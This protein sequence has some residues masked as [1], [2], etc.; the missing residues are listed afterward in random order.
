M[1]IRVA[2]F[3]LVLCATSS[4]QVLQTSKPEIQPATDVL[5]SLDNGTASNAVGGSGQPG[6]GWFNLLKPDTYPATLKEVHIA[7]N[8]DSR[9]LASG[10]PIRIL[11]FVDPEGDGLSPR[12]Q[13]AQILQVT[14]N[15]PGS[16][17]RFEV[18]KP[19]SIETGAF[20][21]GPLD[22]ILVAQLPALINTPGT[23]LPAG[24]RSYYT[25]DNGQT[26]LNVAASFPGFGL[27]PG[28]WLIRAVVEVA[29]PQPI[30]TR[31]FYRKNKLRIVGR[32]F[33]SNVVVRINGERIRK[34]VNF[35]SASGKYIIRGT[36]E[37]LNLNAAGQANTLVVIVDDVA[38][39]VFHFTT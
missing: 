20:I 1:M 3:V 24:A 30:I 34:S 27:V 12:Q 29:T 33:S 23:F 16:F 36:P 39:E 25:L 37:E 19:L 5:L 10:A 11:I 2:L 15:R 13:P 35:D 9:G 17:E 32:N 18:P 21:I 28:S 22:S 26:F 6:F 14:S 8:G 31:A 38:S 4:A 7:F